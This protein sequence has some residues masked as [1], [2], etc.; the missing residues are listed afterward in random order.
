MRGG[1]IRKFS[2][3]AVATSCG[4]MDHEARR[5]SDSPRISIRHFFQ[6]LEE[7]HG[8]ALPY[9]DCVSPAKR[10]R[11]PKHDLL[12]RVN[13]LFYQHRS[14]L[15]EAL[16]DVTFPL[17]TLK[18]ESERVE[19]L[20]TRLSIPSGRRKPCKSAGSEDVPSVTGRTSQKPTSIDVNFKS[21]PDPSFR[22]ESTAVTGSRATSFWS[23]LQQESVPSPSTSIGS[24]YYTAK[25]FQDGATEVHSPDG[26][27][28]AP[29][30]VDTSNE[31]LAPNASTFDVVDVSPQP[32]ISSE[33][34]GPAHTGRWV[35]D[36]AATGLF[37]ETPVRS[38]LGSA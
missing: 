1:I 16:R 26:Y 2:S 21:D 9:K 24:D 7:Q 11:T 25:D 4:P 5:E 19:L 8:I 30:R 27:D 18:K 36:F 33:A 28:I 22:T 13:F 32:A 34:R 38:S 37:Y 17:R 6:N 23:E 29:D 3:T 35:T 12:T 10:Q 14:N 15:E 31:N 20:L